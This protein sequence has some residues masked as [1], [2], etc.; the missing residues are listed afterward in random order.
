[1]KVG[2]VAVTPPR[3][4]LVKAGQKVDLDVTLKR[5]A[6]V[7]GPIDLTLDAPA[8]RKLSAALVRVET[9]TNA[10]LSIAAAA[11]SPTGAE[12]VNIRAT[13]SV[14]G[15]PVDVDVPLSLSVTK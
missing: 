11:D 4:L 6:G 13:V 5:S 2:P 8:K 1:V 14:R 10:R 3:V 15:E 9:G 7:D 12:P